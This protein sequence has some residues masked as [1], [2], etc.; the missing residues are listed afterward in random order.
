MAHDAQAQEANHRAVDCINHGA[1]YCLLAAVRW[2]VTVM[3]FGAATAVDQQIVVALGGFC[4]RVSTR[5]TIVA[6][7][8]S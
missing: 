6:I 8:L 5:T 1:V 7:W 2:G 3:P 4:A